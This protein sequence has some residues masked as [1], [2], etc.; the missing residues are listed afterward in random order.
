MLKTLFSSRIKFN[1][2]T[3]FTRQFAAMV[4]AK[5]PLLQILDILSVQADNEKIKKMFLQIAKDVRAGRTLTE[6]LSRFPDIFSAFYLNMIRVGEMTGRLDYMLNRIAIYLEKMNTLRR[7]LIQA[8]SYPT[9]VILVAIGAVSFILTYVVPAFA[10]MFRDFDAQLP[11][12]TIFLMKFSSFLVNRL[13]VVLLMLTGLI[14]IAQYYF[15]TEKGKLFKDSFVLIMPISGKILK[16][17]YISR[18]SRTLSI[19]LESGIPMLEAL[20]V[21]AD[22]IPNLV[23]RREIM[24]MF[25]FAE[26]GERLTRPILKSK[27]FPIMVTQM[28][29][30]GEET[31]QLDRMLAKVADFYDDEIEAMLN[32]LS[33]ILEPLIII[34]LGIILGTILIALYMPLFDLVNVIPG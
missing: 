4:E 32:N 7:R 5:I 1:E 23:V 15:K 33:S 6:A 3:A 27:I 26:K 31:A 20:K 10:D 17:N 2:L 30:V 25:Y 13:W 14:F 8:L 12:I 28:L 21:T 16:M 18:F 11:T 19:L 24:Q 9:L 29:I 22:S 34:I